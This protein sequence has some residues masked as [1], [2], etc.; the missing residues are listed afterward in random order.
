MQYR[1]SGQNRENGARMTLELEAASRGAAE[2][3]AQQAGMEVQRVE[4]IGATLG[5]PANEPP[6]RSRAGRKILLLVIVLLVLGG[7]ALF[8]KAELWTIYDQIVN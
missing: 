3:K 2:R 6:R 5:V 4:E 1:V 7:A 8:F